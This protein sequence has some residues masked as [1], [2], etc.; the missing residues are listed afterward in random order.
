MIHDFG[1]ISLLFGKF[2][3]NVYELKSRIINIIKYNVEL[4]NVLRY[5][6]YDL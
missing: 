3:L 6:N 1:H 5:T 4:V 2:I